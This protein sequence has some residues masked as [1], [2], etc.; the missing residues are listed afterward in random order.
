MPIMLK[1]KDGSI[2]PY[3]NSEFIPAYYLIPRS[4]LV[5]CGKELN[6]LPRQPYQIFRDWDAITTVESDLFRQ[7]M[8]DGYAHLV[9]PYMMGA[10]MPREVFSGYD[11]AWIFAHSPGYW[12]QELTDE[13]IIPTVEALYQSAR[14]EETFGDVSLEELD[15]IL[16]YIVPKAM[17]HYRMN[18]VLDV[19]E[20]YRCFE[21]FDRRKSNAKTDFFRKWYHTR[22]KYQT[23]SWEDYISENEGYSDGATPEEAAVSTVLVEQFLATLSEKDRRILEL[24]MEGICLEDIAKKLGYSN[25]SGVLKRIQR[26]GQAYEAFT[27]TDLGFSS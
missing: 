6:A 16:R 11:P 25:H 15:M 5:K 10:E 14:P 7:L 24:R 21:D 23:V 20:E 17:E 26:I 13:G 4:F 12:V 18:D 9:W 27:Q 2:T 19:V 22:T 1:R 8:I 3:R